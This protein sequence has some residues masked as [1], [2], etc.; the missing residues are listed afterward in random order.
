MPVLLRALDAPGVRADIPWL[1][2]F[3]AKM[4]EIRCQTTFEDIV[5]RYSDHFQEHNIT[6]R[7]LVRQGHRDALL[8]LHMDTQERLLQINIEHGTGVLN[9]DEMWAFKETISFLALTL[10]PHPQ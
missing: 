4:Q 7:G 1:G 8:H 10:R 2:R 3:N 6:W 9:G 5:R